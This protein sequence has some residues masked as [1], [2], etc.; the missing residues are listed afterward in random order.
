MFT[1]IRIQ[2]AALAAALLLPLAHAQGY[3]ETDPYSRIG[4]GIGSDAP[5][6]DDSKDPQWQEDRVTVPPPPAAN[7]EL[8]EAELDELPKGFR[9]FIDF[10]SL[11]VSPVD[12]AVRYWL[13]VR[14]PTS[15][16]VSYEAI[17]C[18]S[19]E[20]K[21][22]AYADPRGAIRPVPS[23]AWKP[24]GF[25]RVKDYHWALADNYLCSGTTPRQPREVLLALKGRYSFSKPYSEYTEN[26]RPEQ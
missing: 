12:R 6:Y 24:I 13:V 16:N 23:P 11:S 15:A 17:N 21:I 4:R 8:I 1:P 10:G 9:A 2:I 19:R 20:L 18:A 25:T 3:D 26:L 14:T 5:R 22:Y 7:A